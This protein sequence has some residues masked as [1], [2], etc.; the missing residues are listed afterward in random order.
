MKKV[1]YLL[2]LLS[3]LLCFSC[4]KEEQIQ[5]IKPSLTGSFI[6]ERDG[7]QYTW[8]RYGKLD[9]MTENMR[10]ETT[11]GFYKKYC[12]TT[13]QN[14]ERESEKN[15]EHYG[16]LYDYDAAQSVAPEGWR[17]P[18]DADWQELELHLGM[19]QGEWDK[20]GWRGDNQGTLLIQNSEGTGLNFLT[21]GYI[22]DTYDDKW[23][24]YYL[25]VY[26]FFWTA[27]TDPQKEKE[28]SAF[29]RKIKFDRPEI[30]RASTLKVKYMSVR[31]VREIQ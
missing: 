13:T 10:A 1:T 30:Y 3:A 21:G 25:G 8:V 22:D 6:D 12:N 9:W 24:S 15:Y 28:V 14:E 29:Y 20:I 17:L 2:I 31:C 11:I 27:T 19:D 16:Y 7:Y 18:T 4:T 23:Q 26:G 5:Q